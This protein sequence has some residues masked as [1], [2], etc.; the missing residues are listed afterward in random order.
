MVQQLHVAPVLHHGLQGHHMAAPSLSCENHES[1][2]MFSLKEEEND[3]I[4]RK[5]YPLVYEQHAS[6]CYL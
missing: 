2:K 1:Q 6:I 5:I 4:D 3:V